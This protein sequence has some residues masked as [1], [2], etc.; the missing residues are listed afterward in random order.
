MLDPMPDAT[1]IEEAVEHAQVAGWA[2][3]LHF[4]RVQ[5]F[6]PDA[7]LAD[8]ELVAL[9]DSVADAGVPVSAV[10]MGSPYALVR[11]TGAGARLCSYS[12]CDASLR[13]TLRILMGRAEPAGHLPVRLS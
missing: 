10:S 1:Q 8:D 5:S 3:L 7:V 11:F 12:T 4:N 6:D 2:A 13:A 9:A